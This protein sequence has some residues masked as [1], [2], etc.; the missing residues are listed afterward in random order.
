[1]ERVTSHIISCS[2]NS[3][4]ITCIATVS[5]CIY[6]I[7]CRTLYANEIPYTDIESWSISFALR[8]FLL[9]THLKRR[10]PNEAAR[11]SVKVYSHIH[12][13]E[14]EQAPMVTDLHMRPVIGFLYLGSGHGGVYQRTLEAEIRHPHLATG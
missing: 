11:A 6:A 1:V 4:I 5:V 13:Y 14:R 8:N 3:C 2:N 12:N 9:L 10:D 7:I